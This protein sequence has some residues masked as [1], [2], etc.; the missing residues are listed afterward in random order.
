[1]GI[2]Q[3]KTGEILNQKAKTFDHKW[4]GDA[5]AMTLST[6]KSIIIAFEGKNR[7][8]RY[9]N[10]PTP[11][12]NVGEDIPMP[13]NLDGLSENHGIEAIAEYKTNYLII[14]GEGN[15]KKKDPIPGWYQDDDHQWQQ[16]SLKFDEDYTVSDL[17]SLNTDN[18]LLVERKLGWFG[19][20]I[21]FSLLSTK[22]L[23]PSATLDRNI[24]SVLSLPFPTD[25][26]EAIAAYPKTN[27]EFIIYLMSDDNRNPLQRTLFL[28]FSLNFVH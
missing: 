8:W 20:R 4:Q 28:Q 22:Q 13:K 14:M 7:L 23:K 19:W 16:I 1:T 2:N 3:I 21:R 15:E 9:Q 26:F 12:Q 6:N 18:L 25:N 10:G 5:E 17:T 24:I 27:N 11:F